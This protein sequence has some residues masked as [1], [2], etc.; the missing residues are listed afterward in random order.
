[1]KSSKFIISQKDVVN[2]HHWD[3]QK[4]SGQIEDFQLAVAP[5]LPKYTIRGKES[6]FPEMKWKSS[7]QNCHLRGY[8]TNPGMLHSLSWDWQIITASLSLHAHEFKSTTPLPDFASISWIQNAF[9]HPFWPFSP[10]SVKK[11]SPSLESTRK[12][13]VKKLLLFF[14]TSGLSRCWRQLLEQR[15]LQ[16]PHHHWYQGL[17]RHLVGFFCQWDWRS[18]PRFLT[19]EEWTGGKKYVRKNKA[20]KFNFEATTKKSLEDWGRS[21]WWSFHCS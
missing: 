13:T 14:W 21:N 17:N 12:S 9:L 1:M 18:S 4:N 3:A 15:H 6:F 8:V 11:K 20:L 19:R 16:T 10:I 2:V 5:H 7:T